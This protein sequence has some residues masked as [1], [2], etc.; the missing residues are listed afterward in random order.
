MVWAGTFYVCFSAH[1]GSA[2]RFHMALYSNDVVWQQEI[3]KCLNMLFL[4]S[5]DLC[6]IIITK[7]YLY[8]FDPL[9]PHFYIVKLGFTG[10]YIIYIISA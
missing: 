1:R 8:N 5:F 4:L 2:G 7:T 6:F 10:V 9:K 3:S